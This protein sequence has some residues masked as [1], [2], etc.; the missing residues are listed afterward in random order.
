MAAAYMCEDFRL[1]CLP[2]LGDF[3]LDLKLPRGKLSTSQST[4]CRK[5]WVLLS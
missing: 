3:E 5:R 4:D 1:L 2:L